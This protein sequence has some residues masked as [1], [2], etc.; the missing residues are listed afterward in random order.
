VTVGEEWVRN[1]SEREI[2]RRAVALCDQFSCRPETFRMSW[3]AFGK[4]SKHTQQPI[5]KLVNDALPEGFPPPFPT[6][7]S[8]GSRIARARFMKQC[9]ADGRWKVSRTC[10]KLIECIPNLVRDMERNPEDVL[11][12][13][14]SETRLG[15]DPYDAAS[16]GL[17]YVSSFVPQVPKPLAPVESGPRMAFKMKEMIEGM[18]RKTDPTGAVYISN[19]PRRRVRWR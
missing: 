8:P 1:A 7:S 3:D 19:N 9:L 12:V 16:Y 15:D 14:W 6:D 4:L 10:T 11:K 18:D 5:T 2:A 17:Q 13:D